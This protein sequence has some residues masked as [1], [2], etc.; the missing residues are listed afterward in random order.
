MGECP[1]DPA[2]CT[3]N[4]IINASEAIGEQRRRD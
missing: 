2:E 3:M 1:P 4:L